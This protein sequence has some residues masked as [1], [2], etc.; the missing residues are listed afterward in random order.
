MST[1]ELN[2]TPAPFVVIAEFDVEP[3]RL[4]DFLAVARDDAAH[5]VVDEPG[6]QQ[7]EVTVL[8]GASTVV[9]FE[10]YDDRAAFDAHLE[11]PH[12]ARFR[13]AFP[14]LIRSEPTVRFGAL[15]SV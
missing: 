4:A 9:F 10:V 14:A 12:L 13:D 11:T 3:A 1:T 15:R 5:S 2:T 8:E 7:F 6:C